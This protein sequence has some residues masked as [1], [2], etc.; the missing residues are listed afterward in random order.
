MD[1]NIQLIPGNAAWFPAFVAEFP[2]A[3]PSEF[4]LIDESSKQAYLPVSVQS[5]EDD[6]E[7]CVGFLDWDKNAIL[8]CKSNLA[9]KRYKN[10]IEINQANWLICGSLMKRK[11]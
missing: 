6:G 2:H 5:F 11:S 1:E 9:K 10:F 3:T 7:I 8:K 4:Q